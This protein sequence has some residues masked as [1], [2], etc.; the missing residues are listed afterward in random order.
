MYEDDHMDAGHYP[1]QLTTM[2]DYEAACARCE[3]VLHLTQNYHAQI[4]AAGF[5]YDK[6]DASRGRALLVGVPRF[7]LLRGDRLEPSPELPDVDKFE[8]LSEFPVRVVF[9]RRGSETRARH[10]NPLFD[11]LIG[12]VL[13]I[14][15]VDSLHAMNLGCVKGFITHGMWEM[16]LR[17]A[18]QVVYQNQEEL[19]ELAC[20]KIR[21]LLFHWY[22]SRRDF[23]PTRMQDFESG[24][25]GTSTKRSFRIKAAEAKG[26]LFFL[27]DMID[28]YG[29]VLDR[30]DIWHGAGK[31]LKDM[32]IMFD[33]LD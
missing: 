31:A 32:L 6:T 30:P 33:D 14:F 16:I 26:F 3:I 28:A 25:I 8:Q 9:W 19:I 21:A 11:V 20:M 17:N 12:I 27:V 5:K 4:M 22:D 23:E 18:F 1:F 10:R 2:D 13:D 7:G 29:N 15:V 24:M